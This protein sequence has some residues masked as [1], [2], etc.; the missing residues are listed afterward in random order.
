MIIL[1]NNNLDSIMNDLISDKRLDEKD[2][3]RFVL[4]LN[5]IVNT[6]KNVLYCE[7]NDD[8]NTICEYLKNQKVLN[9]NNVKNIGYIKNT[10]GE[11]EKYVLSFTNDEIEEILLI[12]NLDYDNIQFLESIKDYLK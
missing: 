2:K 3:M 10:L 6:Y 12:I 11:T 1:K 9:F 7:L 4:K 5:F 8:K